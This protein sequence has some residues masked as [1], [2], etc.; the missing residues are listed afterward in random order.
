MIEDMKILST[1]MVSNISTIHTKFLFILR[2][3]QGHENKVPQQGGP[4]R[5]NHPKF[6]ELE[7]TSR[8]S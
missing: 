6:L 3:H 7:G 8:D 2:E 5:P 4:K 1:V